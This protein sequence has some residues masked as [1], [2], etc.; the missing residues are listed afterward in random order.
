[1]AGHTLAVEVFRECVQETK[2]AFRMAGHLVRGRTSV[3][4]RL[5]QLWVSAPDRSSKFHNHNGQRTFSLLLVSRK[6]ME[7]HTEVIS[8]YSLLSYDGIAMLPKNSMPAAM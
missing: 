7:T 5:T 3:A 4:I 2:P 8:Y 6:L 1:M